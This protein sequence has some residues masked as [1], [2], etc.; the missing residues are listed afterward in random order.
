MRKSILLKP[1]SGN[2]IGTSYNNVINVIVLLFVIVLFM[3]MMYNVKNRQYFLKNHSLDHV[4]CDNNHQDIFVILYGNNSN[5]YGDLYDGAYTLFNLFSK[6]S[7]PFR[8]FVYINDVYS[9]DII[10]YYENISTDHNI[11]P[12]IPNILDYYNDQLYCLLTK[13]GVCFCKHWDIKSIDMLNTLNDTNIILTSMGF[14]KTLKS[15]FIS[16]SPKSNS[17]HLIINPIPF[18]KSP[19]NFYESLIWSSQY[20]FST[21]K[22][23]DFVDLNDIHLSMINLWDNHFKLY[24]PITPIIYIN[25]F[26][27][28]IIN[29]DNLSHPSTT[30]FL[31]TIGVSD[32]SVKF[33]SI[34]G[35]NINGTTPITKEI[36]DKVGSIK[37]IN[38]LIINYDNCKRITI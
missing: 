35:I 37:K 4:R 36:M 24:T 9:D 20:I 16:I 21:N 23:F 22:I 33:F 27:T 32:T 26:Q 13:P 18:E 6:S 11:D 31:N 14:S 3:F 1:I 30:S 25:N 5:K 2:L 10:K 7:C 29:I 8:V 17:K 12:M 38:K 15:T 34:L 28:E 19:S